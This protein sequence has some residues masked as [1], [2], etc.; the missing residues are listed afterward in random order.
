M[1]L[2]LLR[3]RL[4][5]KADLTRQM[6]FS[7]QRRTDEQHSRTDRDHQRHLLLQDLLPHTHSNLDGLPILYPLTYDVETML[8]RIHRSGQQVSEEIPKH[9]PHL[10]DVRL[11]PELRPPSIH[12]Q[13]GRP[14]RWE[15]LTQHRQRYLRPT[16]HSRITVLMKRRIMEGY[17][18]YHYLPHQLSMS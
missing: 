13:N 17:F 9:R 12:H 15:K 14:H 11:H 16:Q 6:L 3:R 5:C 10:S 1:L 4:P 18:S 7:L 2:W 8:P